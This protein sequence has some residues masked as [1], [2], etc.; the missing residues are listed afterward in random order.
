MKQTNDEI[1]L[2][3]FIIFFIL[4]NMS[5]LKKYEDTFGELSAKPIKRIIYFISFLLTFF[6]GYLLSN[7]LN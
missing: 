1:F 7:I 3:L 4:L 6:C 5:L 2:F